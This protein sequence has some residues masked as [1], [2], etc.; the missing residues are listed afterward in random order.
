MMSSPKI[1]LKFA[2][3]HF[4]LSQFQDAHHEGELAL[5]LT[6]NAERQFEFK[7][8]LANI[9]FNTRNLDGAI[10]TYTDLIK[11]YP[12]K[13]RAENITMNLVVCYEEQESFDKAIAVLESARSGYKDTEFI[14]LKIKR[15]RERKANL[16]GSKGL[17]K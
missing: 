2:R 8:F 12:E 1:I 11:N 17:R 3:A 16:P 9:E 4:N 13:A 7:V 5:K 14:D 15:L 6:D 10:L